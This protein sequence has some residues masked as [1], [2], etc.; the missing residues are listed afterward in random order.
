MRYTVASIDPR[1]GSAVTLERECGA[2]PTAREAACAAGFPAG[3]RLA[4]FCEPCE[5]AR[6][7]ADGDRLD[8]ASPLL[9]DPKAA[10][11]ERARQARQAQPRGF[12]RHGSRRQLVQG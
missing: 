4:V 8:V 10:R 11:A 5:D 12:S 9:A 6:P 3:A 7:L 2:P 1:T